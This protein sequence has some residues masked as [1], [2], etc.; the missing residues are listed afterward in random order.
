M[1]RLKTEKRIGLGFAMLVECQKC[2]HEVSDK[3][4]VCISCGEGREGFLGTPILCAE[5]GQSVTPA[6]PSCPHCGAPRSV[7]SFQPPQIVPNLAGVSEGQKHHVN[8]EP[9]LRGRTTSGLWARFFAKGMDLGIFALVSLVLL[10]FL[11][12]FG[13]FPDS[14]LESPD[15]LMGIILFFLMALIEGT[16]ISIFGTTIG[17]SLMGIRVVT[18][19]NARLNFFK[20]IGRSIGSYIQGLGL[21]IPIVALLTHISA[22]NYVKKHNNTGWDRSAGADYVSIPVNG[23]RWALAIVL[24]LVSLAAFVGLAAL[25]SMNSY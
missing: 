20:S 15:A 17:K 21:G 13:V 5:C 6:L 25:G 18:S 10:F 9:T 12:A 22:F 2:G 23:I 24:Y 11:G 19:S 1:D 4:D 8:V 14:L 7:F 3:A 16:T